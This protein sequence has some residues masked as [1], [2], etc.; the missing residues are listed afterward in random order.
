MNHLTFPAPRALGRCTLS[1]PL[2]ALALVFVLG[3]CASE[4]S[5]AT[6][7]GGGATNALSLART[8]L[9]RGELDTAL[10]EADAV[11]RAAPDDADALAVSGLALLLTAETQIDTQTSDGFTAV[12]LED[13]LERLLRAPVRRETS[14]AAARAAW[15]LSRGEQALEL[16]HAAA[17]T[18]GAEIGA[19]PLRTAARRIEYDAA[20]LA[21]R[22]RRAA[23]VPESEL[24]ALVAEC[25]AQ[26]DA[27]ALLDPTDPW[28]PRA[29]AVVLASAGRDV[30][31][32]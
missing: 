25:L 32:R 21:L 4:R 12:L 1:P 14:Y 29:R 15:L 6:L 9:D 23:S 19:W 11:L 30:E 3:A 20:W 26:L 16:A 27:L 5:P 22:Q 31:H 2:A 24:V 10:V 13:A 8:A 17:R 18:D 7:A 28:T